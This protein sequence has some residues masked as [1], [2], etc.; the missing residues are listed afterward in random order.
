ME[1]AEHGTP[2][3]GQVCLFLHLNKGGR[4]ATIIYSYRKQLTGLAPSSGGGGGLC[5]SLAAAGTLWF[6]AHP[7]IPVG[8]L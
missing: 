5:H 1:R 4:L 3:S 6:L 2:C 8:L 7:A